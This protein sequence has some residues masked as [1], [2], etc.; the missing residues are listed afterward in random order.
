MMLEKA[1]KAF[2][3][4]GLEG[5]CPLVYASYKFPDL[6]NCAASGVPTGLPSYMTVVLQL[7]SGE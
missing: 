3:A 6:K 1:F 5:H 2:F 4:A 7:S